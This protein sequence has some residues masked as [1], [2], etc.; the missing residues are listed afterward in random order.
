LEKV[1]LSNMNKTHQKSP[2]IQR[3]YKLLIWI[4]ERL[5]RFPKSERSA[6]VPKI[7]NIALNILLLLVEAYYTKKKLRMLRKANLRIELLRFL[8]RISKDRKFISYQQYEY[9]TKELIE[10]GNQLGGWIKYQQ[11]REA[12]PPR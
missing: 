1:G 4:Q 10:V 3:Y 6:L 8:M 9:V 7:G 5:V 11:G 12:S 2:L